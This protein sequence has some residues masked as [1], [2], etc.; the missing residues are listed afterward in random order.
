MP[1]LFA[2]RD[3]PGILMYPS[4]VTDDGLAYVREL[5]SVRVLNPLPEQV[6]DAGITHLRGLPLEGLK[7]PPK[8]TDQCMQTVATLKLLRGI[9]LSQHISDTG[10]AHISQ[11]PEL[12]GLKLN[13][14]EPSFIA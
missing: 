12:T 13:N 6:T 3:A 7:L 14:C 2:F 4:Q 9:E 11:L 5:T 1:I 8:C 10:F